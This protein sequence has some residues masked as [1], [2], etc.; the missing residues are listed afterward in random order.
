VLAAEHLATLGWIMLMIAGVAYHVLPRFSGRRIRALR[1]ARA[2]LL[3]HIVALVLIVVG[4]GGG[5][6]Y[7]FALSGMLMAAALALFAWTVW[8]TLVVIRQRPQ[9]IPLVLTERVR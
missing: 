5:L 4:L 9:P 1:W 6:G 3:C 2:H 7:V 8:P